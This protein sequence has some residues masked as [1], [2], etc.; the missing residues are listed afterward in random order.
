[1]AG[2]S[3]LNMGFHHS[4]WDFTTQHG[5]SPLNMGFHHSTWDFTTQH[6]ISPLNMGF[7]EQNADFLSSLGDLEE[8][9]LG[10]RHWQVFQQELEVRILSGNLEI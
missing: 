7:H 1:M 3:P 9:L 5:I 2:I 6:G 8:K 10:F 4:T